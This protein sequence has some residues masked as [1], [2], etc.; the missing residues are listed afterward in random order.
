MRIPRHKF[1]GD[2]N[3]GKQVPAG[4]ATGNDH[5]ERPPRRV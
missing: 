5:I 2:G 1:P 4:A 3:A